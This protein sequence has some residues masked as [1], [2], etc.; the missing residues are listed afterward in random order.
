MDNYN[1][2]AGPPPM[3]AIDQTKIDTA[4]DLIQLTLEA[5]Q[6][7]D[8]GYDVAAGMLAFGALFNSCCEALKVPVATGMYVVEQLMTRREPSSAIH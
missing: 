7:G 5:A 1:T 3:V 4:R 2:D 6:N 8:G